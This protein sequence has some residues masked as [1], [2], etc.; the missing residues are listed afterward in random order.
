[1][2]FR[3]IKQSMLK[4]GYKMGKPNSVAV[5]PGLCLD[6]IEMLKSC[7]SRKTLP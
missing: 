3:I 4:S 7:F 6:L 1:M 5:Q 2:F